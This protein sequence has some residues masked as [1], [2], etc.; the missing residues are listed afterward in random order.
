MALMI[1]GTKQIST[2]QANTK[3]KGKGQRVELGWRRIPKRLD[4]PSRKVLLQTWLNRNPLSFGKRAS[5][6]VLTCPR[7]PT[8]SP[9]K[10]RALK[11]A[12]SLAVN[13]SASER[14]G[15]GR[16]FSRCQKSKSSLSGKRG[17]AC[18]GV[19]RTRSCSAVT[20][21]RYCLAS[22]SKAGLPR[23]RVRFQSR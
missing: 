23:R 15:R 6:D 9:E 22:R 2:G 3:Y 10:N 5:S 8:L 11:K 7:S 13:I 20:S 17:T 4:A 18:L 14:D 16:R 1:S 21:L 19:I 12:S